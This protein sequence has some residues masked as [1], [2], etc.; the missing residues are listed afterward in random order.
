MIR[1]ALTQAID[2]RVTKEELRDA[3]E[4]PIPRTER[5]EVVSLHRWFTTRYPSP[6]G[7]LAYVR[8]AYARW[9]RAIVRSTSA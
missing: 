7:R 8:H 1:S 4:R 2:R 5:D 9:L 3:L 6:E